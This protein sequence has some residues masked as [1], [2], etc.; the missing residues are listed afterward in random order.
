MNK[1]RSVAL[2]TL[3]ALVLGV[4]EAPTALGQAAM[5]TSPEPVTLVGGAKEGGLNAFTAF[6]SEIK[7]PGTVITGH[8]ANSTPHQLIPSGATQATIT[9]H[10]QG[11]SSGGT[12]R[13]V[14]MNGCDGIVRNGV[15][16]G[17]VAG[18]YGGEA[19]IVCPIG[20]QIEITGGACTVK[21]PPQ[22]GLTGLHL[23]NKGT[24]FTLAGTSTGLTASCSF[25]HT[26]SAVAHL[27]GG[28]EA[29][30]AEGEP[31]EATISD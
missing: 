11:C 12:P 13:T 16:T 9:P 18:T 21:F 15:T 25:L 6:G 17:G 26:T 8:K 4:A 29:I 14:K 24:S 27:T 10:F 28:G 23:T 3:C 2:G 19:D 5:G 31:V 22:T 20:S 30:N 1:L 7:C